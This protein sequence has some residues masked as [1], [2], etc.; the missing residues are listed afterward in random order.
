MQAGA[1]GSAMGVLDREIEASDVSL[2]ELL[3]SDELAAAPA[4]YWAA[5]LSPTGGAG[6][7]P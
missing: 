1:T 3:A 2:D 5:S 6:A 4:S 7:R